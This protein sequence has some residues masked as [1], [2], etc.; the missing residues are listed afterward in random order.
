MENKTKLVIFDYDGVLIDT[1]PLTCEIYD[2]YLQEFNLDHNLSHDDYRE[3]FESDWRQNLAKL[4][5]KSEED[6]QKCVNIYQK[7]FSEDINKIK[8]FPG[9][10]EV[11]LKLKQDNYK[12][13]IVS[14]NLNAVMKPQL[15][16]F[17]ITNFFDDIVDAS[18]SLK[19]D[20]AGIFK[21]L[22][23]YNLKP[24]E[25]VLIGDMTA[26]IEAAK[27]AKLKK[28]IAVSWGY[29][30]PSQLKNADIIINSPEKILEVVD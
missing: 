29:H 1:F 15:D 25:A 27:N 2:Q 23:Q 19:P 4:G 5:I 10:K 16:R 22:A 21:L 12:I 3:L 30:H 18:H 28:A 8:L 20:P 17:G 9:I 13:A 26:D 6:I 14:N 7:I 11:L 24:G